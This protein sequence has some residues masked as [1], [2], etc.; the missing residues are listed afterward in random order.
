MNEDCLYA[1]HCPRSLLNYQV[2]SPLH[3]N[4]VLKA[5]PNSR[6]RPVYT[7]LRCM[8]FQIAQNLLIP[9]SRPW[10]QRPVECYHIHNDIATRLNVLNRLNSIL[11]YHF[12]LNINIVLNNVS[13]TT[14]LITYRDFHLNL[15][16]SRSSRSFDRLVKNEH[17]RNLSSSVSQRLSFSL[18]FL[19]SYVSETPT[20][21]CVTTSVDSINGQFRIYHW[22]HLIKDHN[23]AMKTNFL[24]RKL[25]YNDVFNVGSSHRTNFP[26]AWDRERFYL[27]LP[28]IQTVSNRDGPIYDSYHTS[29]AFIDNICLK[30]VFLFDK[31]AKIAPRCSNLAVFTSGFPPQFF[32]SRSLVYFYDV[33]LLLNVYHCYCYLLLLFICVLSLF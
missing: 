9:E 25:N 32:L 7:K 15:R 30:C 29:E 31:L 4:H 33:L 23:E 5:R 13:L 19:R 3:R 14:L 6:F 16:S 27:R 2:D 10:T 28:Y 21:F 26:L 20:G 17:L 22:L 18:I 11:K 24:T 12:A 8:I 1:F